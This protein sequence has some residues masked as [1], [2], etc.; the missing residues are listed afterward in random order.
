MKIIAPEFPTHVDAAIG[1]LNA[2]R[3]ELCE[4][5]RLCSIGTPRDGEVLSVRN[6]VDDLVQVGSWRSIEAWRDHGDPC[7]HSPVAHRSGP[8]GD[9]SV[10]CT[11]SQGLN[12]WIGDEALPNR[13]TTMDRTFIDVHQ[14]HTAC[15]LGQWMLGTNGKVPRD[16]RHNTRYCRVEGLAGATGRN[17]RAY[18]TV[19]RP[20]VDRAIR[21]SAPKP[22]EGAGLA[23]GEILTVQGGDGARTRTSVRPFGPFKRRRSSA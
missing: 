10:V 19:A 4:E 20:M 13:R 12:A 14:S 7:W 15:R 1:L 3:Q 16:R 17:R 8:S 6:A 22:I 2:G 21:G 5:H 18:R 9:G 11:H 23:Q